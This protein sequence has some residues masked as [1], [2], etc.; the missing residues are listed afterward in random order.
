MPCK[1]VVL[2]AIAVSGASALSAGRGFLALN[3]EMQPDRVAKT[4]MKV[5]EEWRSQAIAFSMCS[6]GMECN[7]AASAFQQSCSTIVSAVVQASSGDRDNVAEYM[8]DV[9][10]EIAEKDWRHGRC[11][12]MGKLIADTMKEDAFQN[13]VNFD[14]AALCTKFWTSVVKEEGARVEQERKEQAKAEEEANKADE[15]AKAAEAKRKAEEEAEVAEASKKAEEVV[16][17]AEETAAKAAVEE[18]AATA[19]ED[20]AATQAKEQKSKEDGEAKE[21]ADLKE[22][23]EVAIKNVTVSDE[24]AKA[25]NATVVLAANA[26]VLAEPAAVVAT[27]AAVAQPAVVAAKAN[28]TA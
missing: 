28:K 23:A 16:Q 24:V 13:R 25:S 14:T 26:T 8:N 22:V 9:C 11:T 20:K 15:A 4:L 2:S 18:K 5:E 10:T 27:P 12:V 17:V 6:A 1:T 21:Q 3:D 19:L 7:G